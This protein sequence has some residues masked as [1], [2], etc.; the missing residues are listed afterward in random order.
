M[1][2]SN[3]RFQRP[4]S[5]QYK[6]ACIQVIE[7]FKLLGVVVDNKLHFKAHVDQVVASINKRLYSIN[8]LFYLPFEIK[9]QFFK[10]FI[11]SYF[12][13]CIS[14][15]IY[16]NAVAIKKLSRAYYTCLF[17]LFN[18]T[19]ENLS[20]TA[21]NSFLKYHNLFSFHHRVIFRLTIF[22]Y[23]IKNSKIGPIQLRDWLEAT[24]LE[25]TRYEL[26]S[27]NTVMFLADR[28]CLKYGDITF[29]NVFCNYLNKINYYLNYDSNSRNFRNFYTSLTKSIDSKLHDFICVLPKFNCEHYF[30]F[31]L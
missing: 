30:K 29:K 28:S 5:I 21:I 25:N 18:F 27:N 22:I 1:F 14:L 31:K 26:R 24:T 20:N 17:K 11:L 4:E 13:Y 12:D 8:R 19:F 15:L 3:K 10:S 23:K 6:E 7:E 2:I 9:L 16:F